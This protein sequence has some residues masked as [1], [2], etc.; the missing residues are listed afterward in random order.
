VHAP[1]GSL[2]SEPL[3][4]AAHQADTQMSHGRHVMYAQQLYHLFAWY[5]WLKGTCLHTANM[6][7][8]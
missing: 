3:T 2:I 1:A 8:C 6:S 4:S 5:T 7:Y